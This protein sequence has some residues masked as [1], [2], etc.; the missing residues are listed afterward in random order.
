MSLF[1]QEPKALFF[2]CVPLNANE[3][4]PL[5]PLPTDSKHFRIKIDLISVNIVWDNSI[6]S[7][8]CANKHI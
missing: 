2:M 7:S 6:F 5:T 8:I 3:L 1:G 4:Q